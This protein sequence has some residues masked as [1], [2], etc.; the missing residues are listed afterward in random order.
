VLTP[1]S[2]L[3]LT[4]SV[5]QTPGPTPADDGPS[6]PPPLR[7]VVPPLPDFVA[8]GL[9][10][11]GDLVGFHWSED[12]NLPGVLEQRPVLVHD[13]QVI[14][15]PS[16]EGYT[17][18]MPADLSD[19]GRVVGRCG[20]PAPPGV[21]VSMRSQAFVWDQTLGIRGLGTLPGDVLSYATSISSNGQTILGA[22]LQPS[23]EPRACLW[24]LQPDDRWTPEALPDAAP[25]SSAFLA[26]SPDGRQA[27]SLV[28]PDAVLW[29]NP[30]DGRWSRQVIA[31]DGQLAPRAVND[32]GTVVGLQ[33]TPDGRSHAVVWRRELGIVLLPEPTSF[34]RA[35]AL[36][37]N[38]AGNIVGFT[39]GP[40]GS[41]IGPRAFICESEAAPMRLISE[42]GPG[43]VTATAI[44][45]TRQV[46]GVV[47][48][49][50]PDAKP[51]E[52]DPNAPPATQPPPN[53]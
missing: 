38:A 29:S 28:G 39:D 11:R 20:K 51:A 16:L 7:I 1:T 27:A 18:T 8:A 26:L 37:I 49:I 48:P 22:S 21:R 10:A 42:G 35:E 53:P 41:P 19:E 40:H 13:S 31:R 24:R 12:P 34:V 45:D 3:L 2:L 32:A 5:L 44:N 33:H 47:E 36:A 25:I 30:G 9:N 6:T 46:A 17:A 15:I 4:L 43:F 52:P 14:E 23:G 50:E